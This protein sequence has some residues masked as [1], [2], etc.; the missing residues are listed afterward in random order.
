MNEQPYFFPIRHLSPSAAWHLIDFLESI[1]PDIVLIEGPSDANNQLDNIADYK[2]KLPIAILAYTKELPVRT[3]LYPLAEYSP[4]Y[5]AI[6]WSKKNKKEVRFIDLPS[7]VFLAFEDIK[8]EPYKENTD[9]NIYEKVYKAYK[10]IDYNTFWE[11]NF[12]HNL[13][14]DAFRL[15]MLEFGSN[16]RSFTESK[17]TESAEH[18]VREAFMKA[19]IQQAIE[20]GYKPNKMIVLT[21]AYHT[22]NLINENSLALTEKEI[23]ALPQK[24]SNLTL[25]PY[26]YYRLSNHSGY[27]AG[28]KAPYYFE[29]MWKYMN[30]NKLDK[31][32]QY[33]MTSLVNKMREEGHIKS[34]AEVIEAVRLAIGIAKIH[35][36]SL[37]TLQ[38]LRDGAKTCLGEGTFSKISN[39]VASIEIGTKI[40]SIPDGMSNTALQSNFNFML[41]DLK[42]EKYKTLVATDLILDLRENRRVKTEKAIFLD[43]NRSF[44][45]HQLKVMGVLFAKPINTYQQNTNWKEI[46]SICWQPETEIEIVEAAL[47]GDTIEM[48]TAYILKEKLDKCTQIKEA[49]S[50]IST[51]YECGMA[52]MVSYAI[53]IL[54]SLSVDAN[55][56]DEIAEAAFHLSH[57]IRF[58][59]IRKIDTTVVEPILAQ[60]FL[61]AVLIMVDLADCN[62]DV[63]KTLIEAIEQIDKI[64]TYHEELVDYDTYI[65]EL[66]LLSNRDDRN[67]KVSGVACSILLERALI[68]KEILITEIS[69]RL[70]PGIAAEIGAGWFEGLASRNRYI[71]LS[72][73]TI[74]EKLDEYILSLNKDDL[75]SAIVFLHRT[76]SNFNADEK[77]MVAEN[78]ANIWGFDTDDLSEYLNKELSEEEEKII[79]DLEEFDFDDF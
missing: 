27:G 54:Q 68:N 32:P 15:A 31:L 58:G 65:K 75:K 21:G 28:N 47:Y 64:A 62:D 71:I 7:S 8:E 17:D 43:L 34:S 38:D 40:G 70:L 48:A 18:I 74:W 16:L 51:C 53:N 36:G 73:L 10:D 19:Q 45:L 5:Q 24:A 57:I 9:I 6:R 14:K 1:N 61:R 20:E 56:L 12:E 67:P 59:S 25:M 69:R 63:A 50:F 13:N 77:Y 39:A 55:S 30:Q 76:F 41:K 37:P 4:E 22:S 46:W 26:S 66:T 78:L 29:M 3:I 72:S 35:E 44:F 60:L 2:V 33:Y 79:E 52:K 42:L 49:A 23:K 11:K